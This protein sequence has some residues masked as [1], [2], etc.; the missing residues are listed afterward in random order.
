MEGLPMFRFSIRDVLWLMVVVAL[1]L[2]WLTTYRARTHTAQ[3]ERI[4]RANSFELSALLG[5]LAN[6]QVTFDADGKMHTKRYPTSTSPD[7]EA[8]IDFRAQ[9][10][11]RRL[12]EAEKGRYFLAPRPGAR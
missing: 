5:G 10:D 8:V 4:W 6:V 1:S 9:S 12:F 3:Q 11:P 7:S 2:A